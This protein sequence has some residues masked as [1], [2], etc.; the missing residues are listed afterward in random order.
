MS[1]HVLIVSAS[2]RKGGNSDLLCDQFTQGVLES[3]IKWRRYF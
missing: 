2:P 3:K 1:K